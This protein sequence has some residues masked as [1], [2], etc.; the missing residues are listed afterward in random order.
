[1]DHQIDYSLGQHYQVLYQTSLNNIGLRTFFVIPMKS[2]LKKKITWSNILFL[3]LLVA[4]LIPQSRMFIQSNIQRLLL[5]PPST[6]K[7]VET[8][9]SQDLDFRF[10]ME[11][12]S[13]E[14]LKNLSD[15]PIVLNFW[16]TWCP[17]CVAE[18]PSLEKLY[19]DYKDKAHFVILSNE[20]I[21]KIEAFKK[22]RG[23]SLPLAKGIQ[24]A[25]SL[26]QS[27]SIPATFILSK[28]GEILISEIGANNWNS[29]LV[30]NLLDKLSEE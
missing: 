5:R 22:L 28:K 18:M 15:K 9:A 21:A 10:Q 24:Q 8:L 17:P 7:N 16:A 3:G 26:L 1:M 30:R 6:E 4:M 19:T 29:D 12:G 11:D 14:S 20:E 23:F 13:I 25:P 2:K 27:S